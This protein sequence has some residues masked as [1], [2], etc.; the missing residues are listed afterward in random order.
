MKHNYLHDQRG[1]AMVLE[2]VLVAAVLGL[3]GLAVYQSSHHS[4][5]TAA[6]SNTPA[7]APGS[8][9]GLANSAA[10][11]TEN[12]SSS[13]AALSATADASASQ[14]TDTDVDAT[15]LGGSTSANSF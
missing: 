6:V 4:S 5:P 1:V 8:A 7:A 13:D 12:E 9:I 10:T 3:V 15:N 11:I 2:L 14:V